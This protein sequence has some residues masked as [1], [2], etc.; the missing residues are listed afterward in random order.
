MPPI[1]RSTDN[2]RGASFVA[3]ANSYSYLQLYVFY[4][5]RIINFGG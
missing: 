1:T 2:R 5:Q 3:T 4:R